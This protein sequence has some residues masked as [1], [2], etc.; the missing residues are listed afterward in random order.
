MDAQMQKN[1]DQR[2]YGQAGGAAPVVSKKEVPAKVD[3]LQHMLGD[4]EA[5]AHRLIDRTRPVSRTPPPP[6]EDSKTSAIQE[7]EIGAALEQLRNRMAN[8][9]AEIN[10]AIERIEL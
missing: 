4:L 5:S 10:A 1:Q 7:T 9:D 6:G 3:Q 2:A 8:L